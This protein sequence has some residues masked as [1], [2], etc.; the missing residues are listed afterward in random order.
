MPA[1]PERE[2]TWLITCSLEGRDLGVF[3]TKSGGEI[4]SEEVKYR[5]GGMG[6]EISL[7]GA[8]TIANLTIGRYVDRLRDWPIIKWLAAM[9]GAGRGTIGITPLDFHGV[10][11]GD[12]LVYNG[13]LKQVTPPDIDSMGTDQAMLELEFTIDGD[14]A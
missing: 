12:P 1:A 4:D 11:A 5:P 3:D 2:D 13:T 14:V 7:G 9:A 8:K 6:A 10:R